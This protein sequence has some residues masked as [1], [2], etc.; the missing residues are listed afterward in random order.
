MF[1]HTDIKWVK[2]ILRDGGDGW[3]Y[4]DATFDE[5]FDLQWSSK[6]RGSVLKAPAGDIMLLFQKP[7][8]I[9]GRR[10]YH[11]MLTHLVAPIDNV[12]RTY[13]NPGFEFGRKVLLIAKPDPI[14]AIPN[15]GYFNFFLPNRGP[16]NPFHNL[17]SS[18]GL[19]ENGTQLRVWNLFAGHLNPTLVWNSE[20]QVIPNPIS[21]VEEGDKKVVEHIK[22]ETAQRNA[23]IVKLAK[24]LAYQSGNGRI[25]CECC[26][27]DFIPTYGTHGAGFIECHHKIPIASGGR[28]ITEIGDLAMVCSNCHRMLHRKKNDG[29][30]FTVE[31]LRETIKNNRIIV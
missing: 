4:E 23:G 13:N 9:N 29:N 18:E 22:S 7:T 2:N 31:Q 15:L 8:Y 21:G 25:L 12:L 3:A 5:P 19:D 16:T 10:N 17:V 1:N 11:V 6:K 20:Y 24:E 14:F 28:R 30:Y 26:D 27:F